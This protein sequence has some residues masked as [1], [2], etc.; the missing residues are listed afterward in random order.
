M[1]VVDQQLFLISE[2]ARKDV[3]SAS[4]TLRGR[5]RAVASSRS[6]NPTQAPPGW[7]P[8]GARVNRSPKRPGPSRW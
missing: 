6:I 7:Y 4:T 2:A 1:N 3:S 5:L 8:L